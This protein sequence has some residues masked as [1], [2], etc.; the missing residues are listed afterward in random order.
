MSIELCQ[1]SESINNIDEIGIMMALSPFLILCFL[2]M[3]K[4]I[5]VDKPTASNTPKTVIKIYFII[6]NI[7]TD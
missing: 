7:N 5:K 2:L 4:T 6:P 3:S 1:Q